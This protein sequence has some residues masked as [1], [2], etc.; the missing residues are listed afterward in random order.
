MNLQHPKAASTN[1]CINCKHHQNDG[2]AKFADRCLRTENGINPVNGQI[3]SRSC[4]NE[5][6]SSYGETCGPSGIY[7]AERIASANPCTAQDSALT[8]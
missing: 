4:D 7:F 8:P 1:I 6:F 2:S 3:I 5:R